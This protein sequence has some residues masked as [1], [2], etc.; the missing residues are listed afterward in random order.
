MPQDAILG[1]SIS[2]MDYLRLGQPTQ[3]PVLGNFQPSLRDYSVARA[4]P[5]LTS[6]ATL[7]RPSGTEFGEGSS[8]TPSKALTIFDWFTHGLKART[9]RGEG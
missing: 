6:W 7:S 8:H 9:L 5:G 1:Y 2:E 4:N 3:D